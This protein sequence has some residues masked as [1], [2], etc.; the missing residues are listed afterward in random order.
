[1]QSILSR[2]FIHT[3]QEL[4]RRGKVSSFNI[5]PMLPSEL[6]Q[7]FYF[8][9]KMNANGVLSITLEHMMINPKFRM[10]GAA[11]TLRRSADSRKNQGIQDLRY[12]DIFVFCGTHL[13]SKNESVGIQP[14]T[15]GKCS[16]CCSYNDKGDWL[17]NSALECLGSSPAWDMEFVCD[18]RFE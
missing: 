14:T 11:K 2:F 10:R 3:S 9:C 6:Q 18:R 13:E 17:V 15:I 16:Y 7:G 8:L 4:C 5:T 12:S 1:V